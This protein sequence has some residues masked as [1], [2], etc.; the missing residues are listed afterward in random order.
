MN[1]PRSVFARYQ[2]LPLPSG[3]G[4]EIIQHHA[5]VGLILRNAGA[6]NVYIAES[7]TPFPE[8]RRTILPGAEVTFP[9]QAPSNRLFAW[10][11]AAHDLHVTEVYP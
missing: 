4:Y 9:Q 10:A 3:P 5:K 7:E 8:Y 6:S 2:S 1:G 11:D